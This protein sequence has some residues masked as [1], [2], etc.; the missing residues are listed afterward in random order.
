[1]AL[2][3]ESPTREVARQLEGIDFPCDKQ[4]LVEYARRKGANQDTV[5]VLEQLPNERYTSMADVFKGIG[6]EN[7]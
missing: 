2:T 3:P 4:K 7:Q 1:M 6:M 5:S